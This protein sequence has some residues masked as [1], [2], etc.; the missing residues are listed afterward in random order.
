MVN[1]AEGWYTNGLLW[2]IVGVAVSLRVGVLACWATLK[3]ANPKLRLVY[4]LNLATKLLG[5]HDSSG[6]HVMHNGEALANPHVA[7]V[8]VANV[9]RRDI[10]ASMFHGNTPLT[11]DL[12]EPIL[13]LLATK[14]HPTGTL[15]PPMVITD[16]KL[17]VQPSHIVRG[18]KV[19]YTLLLDGPVS[20]VVAIPSLVNVDLRKTDSSISNFM[21]SILLAAGLLIAIT[22]GCIVCIQIFPPDAID[23]MQDHVNNIWK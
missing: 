2:T 7:E 4:R 17:G 22:V 15:A 19:T 10:V 23:W 12:G 8:L 13:T 9:G 1:L 21:I 3:A 18:Q 6:L 11:L 16:T 20:D 14:S 5:H